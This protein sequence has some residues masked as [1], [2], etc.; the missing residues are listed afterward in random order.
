MKTKNIL[1]NVLVVSMLFL[2]PLVSKG[3]NCEPLDAAQLKKMLTELGY[4]IKDLET[5]P[6]KEKY[7]VKHTVRGFDI[8]VAYEL[9]PSKSFIWLTVVLGK[10]KADTSS[11]NYTLLQRNSRVQPCLFYI[12][13][14]TEKLMMGLGVENRGVTNAILRKHT[15]KIV[16]DVVDNATYWQN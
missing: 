3:Q 12:N 9:S 6:G 1:L 11:I 8:P 5:N 2:V 10:P 15:D 13:S 14:V 7:E 16:N 4:T